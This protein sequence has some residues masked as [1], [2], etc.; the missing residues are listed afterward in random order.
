[1][2]IPRYLRLLT[3][4]RSLDFERALHEIVTLIKEPWKI[5]KDVQLRRSATG[6]LF[7]DDPA[8][9]VLLSAMMAASGV[10]WGITTGSAAQTIRLVFYMV[11][12]D[13]LAVGFAVATVGYVLCNYMLRKKDAGMLRPV[14]WSYFF[15]VH[16][17]SFL[18]VFLYIYVLQFFL[19]PILARANWLSVILSDTLYLIAALHYCAISLLGYSIVWD[20]DI[21]IQCV[22]AGIMLMYV[23]LFFGFVI[24]K[25]SITQMAMNVYF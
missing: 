1:M 16:S 11:F 20:K 4:P 19:L 6:K 9:H 14:E 2:K 22:W 18:L 17:N 23:M 21:T 7:R 12:V 8:F 15:D 3:K 5:L 13:Y 10:V 25:V 24:S